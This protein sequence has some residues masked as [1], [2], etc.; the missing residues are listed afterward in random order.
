MP[1]TDFNGPPLPDLERRLPTQAAIVAAE[2]A[3][4]LGLL[5]ASDRCSG[6]RGD[7]VKG[8]AHW[9]NWHL[10]ISFPIA[11]LRTAQ[12]GADRRA[13]GALARG[14][15]VPLMDGQEPGLTLHCQAFQVTNIDHPPPATP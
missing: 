15:A 1:A 8:D 5:A 10:D 13:H 14:A 9:M 7:G 6:W 2:T 11:R 3:D 4:F 12:R